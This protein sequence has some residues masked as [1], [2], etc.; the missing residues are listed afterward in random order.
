MAVVAD[1]NLGAWWHCS[2]DAHCKTCR[3]VS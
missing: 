3:C 2:D 1:T